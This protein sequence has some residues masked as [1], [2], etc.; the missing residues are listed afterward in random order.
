L[1]PSPEPNVFLGKSVCLGGHCPHLA[2][3]N[4]A[5]HALFQIHRP[6]VIKSCSELSEQLFPNRL[7]SEN[8]VMEF[9]VYGPAR[10]LER[11]SAAVVRHVPGSPVSRHLLV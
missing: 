5:V 1:A 8:P 3:K 9:C 10:Q 4:T 11:L 7:E 2:P 6:A